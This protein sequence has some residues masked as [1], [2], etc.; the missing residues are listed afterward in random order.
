MRKILIISVIAVHLLGNTELSQLIKLPNLLHHFLQ[1]HR[2]NG[3]ITFS[4]F[5]DMHYGGDDGTD[6]D[7]AEDNKLPC[8]GINNN[9]LT[10]VYSF[11]TNDADDIAMLIPTVNA[12]GS[13]MLTY[14][15]QPHL[16]SFFQPPRLG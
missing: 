4:E 13:R 1:H 12:Y 7:N 2:Q 8:H 16:F 9:T 10:V 6:A 11:L 5:L 3:T 14:I 15:P